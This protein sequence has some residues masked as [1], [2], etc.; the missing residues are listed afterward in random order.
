MLE[1]I[2]NLIIFNQP[3]T[4]M[5]PIKN[6]KLRSIDD[7]NDSNDP[8]CLPDNGRMSAKGDLQSHDYRLLKYAAEFVGF[9]EEP[10]TKAPKPPNHQVSKSKK[11]RAMQ[12]AAEERELEISKSQNPEEILLA[13][14]EHL[15]RNRYSVGETFARNA[16]RLLNYNERMLNEISDKAEQLDENDVEKAKKLIARLEGLKM[17]A[18]IDRKLEKDYQDVIEANQGRTEQLEAINSV[19]DYLHEITEKVDEAKEAYERG[20]EFVT[21]RVVDQMEKKLNAINE[22]RNI[23]EK[24]TN[25]GAIRQLLEA[26]NAERVEV[27]KIILSMATMFREVGQSD[28]LLDLA[29]YLSRQARHPRL[30]EFYYSAITAFVKTHNNFEFSVE[31]LERFRRH[32]RNMADVIERDMHGE[33]P[34]EDQTFEFLVRAT[35]LNRKVLKRALK[36]AA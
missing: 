1:Y 11:G 31:A 17:P 28:V 24:H 20:L 26:P 9:D 25:R 27:G 21:G 22:T 8:G 34:K 29:P 6:P 3:P 14:D 23:F 30:A 5:R 7:Y 12:W 33:R 10:S 15:H 32:N 16:K 13:K 18:I 2:S 19:L 35:G 36:L 4:I